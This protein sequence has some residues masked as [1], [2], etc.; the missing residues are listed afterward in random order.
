MLTMAWAVAIES[1]FFGASTATSWH[2]H[3]ACTH[4]QD[5]QHDKGHI[6]CAR[7]LRQG[8]LPEADAFACTPAFIRRP[9]VLS[10]GL[11]PFL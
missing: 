2:L 6:G 11:Q 7:A 8:S 1:E 5:T 3:S 9:I 4:S 10:E